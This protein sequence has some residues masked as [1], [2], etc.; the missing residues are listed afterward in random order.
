MATIFLLSE[1]VPPSLEVARGT[2]MQA[3]AARPCSSPA[4]DSNLSKKPNKNKRT[5]SDLA[6]P[7][8]TVSCVEVH[9]GILDVQEFLERFVRNQEW[10][11]LDERADEQTLTYIRKLQTNELLNYTN[12]RGNRDAVVWTGGK[13]FIQM[14]TTTLSQGFTRIEIV[15][16]FEGHGENQD[17]FAPPKETWPLES[18]GSLETALITAVENHFRSIR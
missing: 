8:E 13:A 1:L 18:N 10:T 6:P 7:A 3:V 2:P 15:V 17:S 4:S 16:T 14:K 11:L 9:S 5:K 12:S